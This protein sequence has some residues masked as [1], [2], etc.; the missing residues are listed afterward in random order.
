MNE[1]IN[2]NELERELHDHFGYTS[3]QIGQREIINDVMQG[4][5]VLG[6]LPTGMGKSM[7]FQLPAKLLNGTTIVV[8]PLI[9]LMID[10]VKQLKASNF[11]RVVA[12]NSFLSPK[13]RKKVYSLLNQYKLIY[14]SPELLQQ[15]ELMDY[16]KQVR[17]D[18]LV[19]DEAHCI[20]QW[21]HDFRPDYL[22]LSEVVA[23]LNNPSVLALSATATNEI[24]R[25]I[26]QVLQRPN[27][28]DHIYPM[29]RE[30]IVF[31]VEKL[32]NDMEKNEKISRIFHRIC[33]PT[34][35]YFSSRNATEQFTA[36]LLNEHPSLR[37]AF[38]HG[39]MENV[40]RIS[41]QQQFMNDQLD[42]ICCT[43]AFGMG[44]N[45]K[46]IRFII[47]YHFPTQLESFI[48]EVGRAG[49]D[50]NE[51]VSLVLY[52]EH[53][54]FLP[55]RLIEHELPQKEALVYVFQQLYRMYKQSEQ[56]PYK[57][58][59][60]ETLFHLNDSQWRF[61]HYHLE[62]HGMIK[63]NQ[64]IY[65]KENWKAAFHSINSIVYNRIQLKEQKLLQ[66]TSWVETK[67]CLRE[68]LYKGFQSTFKQPLHACCSN[69]GFN[70]ENWNPIPTVIEQRN[71]SWKEKLSALFSTEGA[72][73][74]P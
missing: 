26:K 45:K 12:L 72:A 39:G 20:S 28:V 35:I 62:K 56:I 25:D 37:V 44:I 8:S 4:K 11:K 32:A 19:I 53:D 9:S 61:L 74:V 57:V 68:Q 7:C 33:V 5:D 49:R 66:M 58:E 52:S 70:L 14:V 6:V 43:S 34:I 16:L 51:S 46:D 27:M 71:Q 24:Q 60:I 55:A 17:V 59:L 18:L 38:Y 31:S 23:E 73:K 30:N 40:D 22:R 64:I 10:Q 21:G 48:Q 13:V 36:F 3:F 50:G 15:R 42:V 41:I 2:N 67:S 65:Q 47:H 69:C 54:Y 1:I 63:G 29:D